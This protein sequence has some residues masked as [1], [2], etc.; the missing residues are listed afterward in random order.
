MSLAE[1]RDWVD[2]TGS[3]NSAVH[4]GVR[5]PTFSPH[6][7]RQSIAVCGDL[8]HPQIPLARG[9]HDWC[10]CHLST[11]SFRT[12]STNHGIK[13]ARGLLRQTILRDKLVR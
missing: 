1:I 2:I 11:N 12:A 10:A 3:P 9:E 5:L 13:A 4:G 8:H 6:N 7:P